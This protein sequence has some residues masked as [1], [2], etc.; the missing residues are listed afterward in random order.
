MR[1]A[2]LGVIGGVVL[3]LMVGGWFSDR[4]TAH[5]QSSTH[6][7]GPAAELIT[8]VTAIDE[9]RQQLVVIDPT[10]RVVS[11]Y[12]VE[13]STGELSLKSVRNIHWDLQMSEFNGQSPLP[14]EIRSLMER[15]R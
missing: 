15:R 14:R 2:V 1:T 7:A 9:R 8:H 11:V 12:H 10:Q 4:G 3:A 13:L 5:A 6:R